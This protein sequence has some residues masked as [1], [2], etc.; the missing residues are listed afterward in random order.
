MSRNFHG[1]AAKDNTPSFA[2]QLRGEN[3][4]GKNFRKKSR[5]KLSPAIY[6][7]AHSFTVYGKGIS[8]QEDDALVEG[9]GDQNR[10]KINQ[11][12]QKQTHGSLS[13][14]AFTQSPR[15]P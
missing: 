5:T 15:Q 11:R 3:F 1:T 14:T 10:W 7:C 8:T 12:Q 9:H 6:I 13:C 2:D 4:L